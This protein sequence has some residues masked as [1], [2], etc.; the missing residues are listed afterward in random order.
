L[1]AIVNSVEGV[2]DGAEIADASGRSPS[3]DMMRTFRAE[4]S[5]LVTRTDASA[6]RER[7]SLGLQIGTITY[8]FDRVLPP[9]HDDC[10]HRRT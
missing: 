1:E 4:F 6:T 9:I 2:E 10:Y 5:L 8:A 3:V 7:R